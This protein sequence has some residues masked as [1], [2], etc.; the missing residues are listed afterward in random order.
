MSKCPFCNKP[1]SPGTTRCP[2]CQ[3]PVS[4]APL[5]D[6]ESLEQQV[7]V[8]LD[9]QQKIEAIKLYRQAS[10]AGLADAKR[11]VEALPAGQP[12]SVPDTTIPE[13][14]EGDLLQRLGAGKKIDAIKLYRQ[15]TGAGL[16]QA[17]QAVEALGQRHGVTVSGGGCLSVVLLVVVGGALL[18]WMQEGP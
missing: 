6:R 8:L 11:A 5:L 18:W 13:G 3:A 10:G 4:A 9:Q 7:R 17:K 1:I 15:H 12:L 14:L 2:N 16:K